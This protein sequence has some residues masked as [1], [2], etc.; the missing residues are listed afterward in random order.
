MAPRATVHSSFNLPAA[1]GVSLRQLARRIAEQLIHC[2]CPWNDLL[3]DRILHDHLERLAHRID[4]KWMEIDAV[5]RRRHCGLALLQHAED[6]VD[7]IRSR[8]G[9]LPID[10]E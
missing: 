4:T 6:F 2:E 9:E 5:T 1:T 3:L 8:I 7:H 10:A